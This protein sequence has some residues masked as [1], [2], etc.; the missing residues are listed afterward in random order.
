[1]PPTSSI[2]SSKDATLIEKEVK[3]AVVQRFLTHYRIPIFERFA[4]S[5]AFDL[6]VY[7]SDQLDV[8][9]PPAFFQ[10]LGGPSLRMR[11]G[12]KEY[13]LVFYPGIMISLARFRPDVVIFEGVTNIV[14]NLYLFPFA[15]VMGSRI[16]WWD[17]GRR[18]GAAMHLL[19]RTADLFVNPM[20]RSSDACLAYGSLAA[21]HMEHCGVAP[22]RIFVAHNSIDDRQVRQ[23]VQTHRRSVLKSKRTRFGTHPVVLYVG[24]LERRKKVDVLLAAFRLIQH[25]NPDVWLSIVGDGPQRSELEQEARE[26]GLER[27]I[28]EGKAVDT[29]DR[30][31]MLADIFVLPAEGGLAI[32]QAMIHGLPVIVS[33]ADG[34]EV[35]LVVENH[36][37]FIVEEGNVQQLASCMEKLVRNAPLRRRLGANSQRIISKTITPEG[38]ILAM[39]DAVRCSLKNSA[40]LER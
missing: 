20:M 38:M 29:V 13:R 22:A 18:R 6:R 26:L 14:N 34:T 31:F 5:G 9:H 7:A 1:M 11:F 15:K 36:N 33:S 4:S 25:N 30:F 37:G 19:R 24:A 3:I 17:A 10:P 2:K 40:R 35:D 23:F 12:G 28:F 21:R 32:N 8:L 16:I 27:V 39:K